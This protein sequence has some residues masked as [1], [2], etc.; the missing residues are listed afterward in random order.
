M[1]FNWNPTSFQEVVRVIHTREGQVYRA[2]IM[3]L[4]H[5]GSL[6]CPAPA[7]DAQGTYRVALE[8]GV[9]TIQKFEN[10]NAWRAACL[11]E[12]GAAS[13]AT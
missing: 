5:V 12:P 11:H 4:K 1:R 7:W 9:P 6:S 8:N 3:A 10:D 2:I 13:S